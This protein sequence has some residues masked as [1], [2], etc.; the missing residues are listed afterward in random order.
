MQILEPSVEKK[1]KGYLPFDTHLAVNFLEKA[2][3]TK[4]SPIDL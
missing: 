3:K 1:I 4:N 2:G